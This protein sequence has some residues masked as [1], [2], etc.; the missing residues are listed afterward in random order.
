[1]LPMATGLVQGAAPVSAGVR[2]AKH[3]PFLGLLPPPTEGWSDITGL[4]VARY[5]L[6]PVGCA[7]L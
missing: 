5:G 2:C 3:F 4:Y 7:N 6:P 1:M